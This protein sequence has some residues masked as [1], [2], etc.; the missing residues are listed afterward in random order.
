MAYFTRKGLNIATVADINGEPQ[1][2]KLSS[3]HN[4]FVDF[5][6]DTRMFSMRG[7]LRMICSLACVLSEVIRI[8]VFRVVARVV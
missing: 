1:S 2:W 8:V 4:C 5:F 3:F 6:C 7:S